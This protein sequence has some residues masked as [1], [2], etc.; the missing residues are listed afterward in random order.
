VTV[1]PQTGVMAH[2]STAA[3][4]RRLNKLLALVLANVVLIAAGVGL[5]LLVGSH[6]HTKELRQ[7]R[8]D[9]TVAAKQ[10]I[11]NLDGVS[12]STADRDF[13]RI[14]D[15]TTGEFKKQFSTIEAT[16]KALLVSRKTTSNALVL[17]TAVVSSSTTKASILV[18]EDRTVS[19]NTTT[20]PAVRPQRWSVTVVKSNDVWLVSGL[21]S[22]V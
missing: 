7:A 2:D 13:E 10:L 1:D 21:A 9:A 12:A 16:L 5:F 8:T 19:D 14:N 17:S 20:Q 18:A 4:S 22:V 3:S 6:R 11:I 15:S